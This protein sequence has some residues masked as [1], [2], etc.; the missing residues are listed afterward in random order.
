MTPDPLLARIRQQAE[1]VRSLLE[2]GAAT[3]DALADLAA[4]VAEAIRVEES[5]LR[6][7]EWEA[8][9][10]AVADAESLAA[11]RLRELSSLLDEAGQARRRSRAYAA[12]Q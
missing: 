2:Q 5:A 1:R 8:I 10:A 7:D 11:D 9:R 6:R 3:T 12:G 4:L